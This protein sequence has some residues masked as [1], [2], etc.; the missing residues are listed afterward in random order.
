MLWAKHSCKIC[1]I[2][3]ELTWN[4][5]LPIASKRIDRDQLKLFALK[6]ECTSLELS[7]IS[8]QLLAYTPNRGQV[9]LVLLTTDDIFNFAL[10]HRKF[11]CLIHLDRF[12]QYDFKQIMNYRL[13]L[14]Y[15]NLIGAFGNGA[16]DGSE[17]LWQTEQLQR[18]A[19]SATNERYV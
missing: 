4:F 17:E 1:E 14:V 11:N 7:Q 8:V 12:E 5:F 2:T 13:L 10:H 16:P 9:K 6:E 19:N 15:D 3:F 18:L